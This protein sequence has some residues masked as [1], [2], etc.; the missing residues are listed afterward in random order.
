MTT[1]SRLDELS[2]QGITLDNMETESRFHGVRDRLTSANA[3]LGAS[4]IV[5]ALG[6][7]ARIVL[8]GRTADASLALAPM[9]YEFG[10]AGDDWNRLAA[11]IVLAGHV[12]ECGAQAS[13][14][15]FLGD[16]K[17][18]RYLAHIGFP[19]AEVRPDGTSIITK[20]AN[21]GGLVSAATV[22]EQLV[23]EIGDPANYMTPDCIAD[24]TTIQ[25]HEVAPSK[26][27]RAS[28]TSPEKKKKKKT[29][30]VAWCETPPWW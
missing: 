6:Q 11:G 7:G 13:G 18:V 26:T 20:H 8:T 29:K 15:N 3:Y 9:I 16:W 17:S 2:T 12:L 21:S 5:A 10:W 24:F 23:Y 14:G 27:N 1:S 4:P 22:K 19:I 28:Q 30:K 25:L